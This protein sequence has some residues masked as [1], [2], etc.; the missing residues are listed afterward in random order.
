MSWWHL[1]Y[2]RTEHLV[3]RQ[4]NDERHETENKDI[5]DLEAIEKKEIPGTKQV[6]LHSHSLK[7]RNFPKTLKFSTFG[8]LRSYL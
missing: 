7:N 1:E 2:L 8:M 3:Q 4:T 5:R 6:R